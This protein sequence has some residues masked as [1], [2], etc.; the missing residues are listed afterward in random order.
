MV[1]ERERGGEGGKEGKEGIGEESLFSR[2]KLS[3]ALLPYGTSMRWYEMVRVVSMEIISLLNQPI[4]CNEEGL[5]VTRYLG[6][7]DGIGEES[8]AVL[9]RELL[10]ADSPADNTK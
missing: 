3:G 10:P 5:H 1:G 7:G 6:E 9:R 8:R 4:E 2:F